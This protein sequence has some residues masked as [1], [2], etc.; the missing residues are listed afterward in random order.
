[1][2]KNLS[3]A[4]DVLEPA[5]PR[6]IARYFA[7]LPGGPRAVSL[8]GFMAVVVATVVGMTLTSQ[9]LGRIVD[10][11]NGE[12]I[13]VFGAGRSALVA[14]LAAIAV[15]LFV[16]MFGRIVVTFLVNKTAR[17]Q[18]VALRKNALE[19]VIRTPVPTIMELG[20]GNV[21]T[22][23]SKDIDT[24]VSTIS[25]MGDRLMIT[26]LIVPITIATMAII[27]PAY[28]VVF[29]M[30][31]F[32]MVPWVKALV[33]DIPA[34]TNMVSSVEAQRNNIL[35]DT[36]RALATLRKFKL[37]NW[38]AKR[39]T[40]YSWN[41]VQAWADKIPLFNRMIMQGTLA[42]GLL[43]V[44]SI[45]LSKLMVD[46]DWLTVGQA[47]A[48]VLLI[49]RLEIH[50]FNVLFFAGEIQHA[51][52]SLGRA[53]SLAQLG[54]AESALED[55][56]VPQL[57]SSAPEVVID[58]LS[59]AYPGGAAVLSDVSVTLAPGSTTALVGTSGAGKST[60]AA[61]VAGLQY[62]TSGSILVGGIDTSTVPNSWVTQHVALVTQDVHLFSGTLRDDLL[63]AAPDADDA[64]L[65]AALA[66]VGL[67][68][69]SATW[70]RWLP[71]GLDTL[72][73]A[74][75]EEVGP[76]VAQQI[77]LARMVLRQPPVLIMDEATSEAGSEHAVT[78]ENAARAVTY[79]RTCLVVAHRL[80]QAREA[81][82][83]LVM[84]QGRIV[85]DGTHTELI[86]LDGR[87]ARSYAQWE[88]S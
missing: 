60:L 83:I 5:N 7:S 61:L 16:E 50:V 29:L 39:M 46:S 68:P 41:T 76:D 79:G 23:L 34:V 32:V 1:M 47:T 42:F 38:A 45:A 24:A 10:I 86:A 31:G 64:T 25:I 43:L 75:N 69:K 27:H 33:R 30:V 84:E 13:P 18:S 40:A 9:I 17:E 66:E 56:D 22:R 85:E 73:G 6:T 26:V 54:D 78:L 72:I 58:S 28:L 63:L 21:I 87:Y 2:N 11:I 36:I 62:P 52:T 88:S 57:T 49:M 20:T 70:Q 59:F 35:L 55:K 3:R 14:A 77:S 8:V 19:S 44:G 4:A 51:L 53:V 74:G 12:E 81:D 82:R 37:G 48:A 71:E 15:G 65:L 80:D 67:V